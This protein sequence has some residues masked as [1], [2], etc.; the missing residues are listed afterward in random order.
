M[1]AIQVALNPSVHLF[2]SAGPSRVRVQYDATEPLAPQVG[3]D[4]HRGESDR[5]CGLPRDTDGETTNVGPWSAEQRGLQSARPGLRPA[6]VAVGPQRSER[7]GV[8]GN[9][10]RRDAPFMVTA[11]GATVFVFPGHGSRGTGA[12]VELFDSSPDFA[13]QMRLCEVAFAEFVDWS[14]L[15]VVRG[16]TGSPSL[17][18]VDVAQPVLFAVMVSLAAHWRAL[19]IQPD[20]VLGHSQGEIAAAYVAG[21]LSLRDAAMVVTFRSRAIRAMA[22]TGGMV[23]IACAMQRIHTLIEPWTQS[24]SVAA[25]NGPR[26]GI[27]TGNA[28]AL[29]ALMV[30]CERD[31]VPATRIPIDYAS[32]SADVE[33]LRETLH[34]S[35]S[36]LR[37]R[38]AE[39][40][41]ISG[42]TGAGLDTTILDNDYWFA[43]LR[44]PVLFEQGVRWAYEHGY[45]TFV[46]SSPRPVLTIDIEE[47][48]ED[49][50]GDHRVVGSQDATEVTRR[51]HPSTQCGQ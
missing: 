11:T 10:L 31:E 50:A 42:V 41:F 33:P 12:A 26:T 40:A 20:A 38:A 45:R 35:L 14:L 8:D 3:D 9:R 39:L 18:R 16:G 7:Q 21:A 19:G 1:V 15:E 37:P 28:A 27:V 34:E 2:S 23:S 25:Q 46:E 47:S 44:Q 13:D 6:R 24:I 48:L 4:L 49:Y 36:G 22:R 30:V 32:H 51:I 17:D 5:R 29:D 43:N